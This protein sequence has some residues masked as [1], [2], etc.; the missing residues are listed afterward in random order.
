MKDFA[1]TLV[2]T[3]VAILASVLL[4]SAFMYFYSSLFLDEEVT[5]FKLFE[6]MYR[7]SFGKRFSIA[8]TLQ[9]AAPL[10]LAA[11]CTAL[12]MRVGL[13]NIGA[14]GALLVGGL[15]AVFT[16]LQLAKVFPDSAPF[17]LPQILMALAGMGAGGLLIAL[18]GL[19]RHLRGVNETISCS[20]RPAVTV[21]V[22]LAVTLTALL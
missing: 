3:L 14:E 8:N 2:I 11:L 21:F 19:L 6:L 5:P 9:K 10:I 17:F 4:F 20:A 18:V 7:G 16:G 1:Q 22:L 12:P 15:A 13:I